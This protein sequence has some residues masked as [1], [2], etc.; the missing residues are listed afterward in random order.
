MIIWFSCN[1]IVACG[2]RNPTLGECE[3]E[4]H[5]FEMGTWES[6][7]TPKTLEFDFRGQNTLYWGVLYII[8]K[9]SKCRCR[10]WVHMSHLNICSTSNFKKKRPESNWQFDSRPLEVGN[11]PDLDACR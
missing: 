11:R 9:L 7:G 3:D 10:K 8:G 4:T 2:C 6:P 1:Y 5:T